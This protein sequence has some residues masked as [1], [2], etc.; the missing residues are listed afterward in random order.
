MNIFAH[1]LHMQLYVIF[2]FIWSVKYRDY[3]NRQYITYKDVELV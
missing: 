3:M 1:K 2:M